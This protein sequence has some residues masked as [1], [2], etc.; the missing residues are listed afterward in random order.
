MEK[1]EYKYSVEIED[2]PANNGEAVDYSQPDHRQGF[3][4]GYAQWLRHGLKNHLHAIAVAMKY[5]DRVPL[6][7]EDMV[8]TVQEL[9]RLHYIVG[10]ALDRLGDPILD[11][12]GKCIH[13]DDLD[14]GDA[15]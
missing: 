1:V 3:K 10:I 5:P 8:Q 7:V 12:N 13:P 2:Y 9:E 14:G 4:M 6:S 15:D 11:A